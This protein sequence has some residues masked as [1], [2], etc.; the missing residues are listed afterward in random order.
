[1]TCL[2]SQPVLEGKPFLLFAGRT[3]LVLSSSWC[4]R[5]VQSSNNSRAAPCPVGPWGSP[6]RHILPIQLHW[7]H[8]LPPY[9]SASTLDYLLC[10]S[11]GC[12]SQPRS[13]GGLFG[14]KHTLLFPLPSQDELSLLSQNTYAIS[15][16]GTSLLKVPKGSEIKAF[17]AYSVL[18]NLTRYHRSPS[19]PTSQEPSQWLN[20][21]TSLSLY[22]KLNWDNR[23][24]LLASPS[25]IKDEN[26]KI[27]ISEVLIIL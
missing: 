7:L 13:W 23:S 4:H 20:K 16:A 12:L 6:W 1:M 26:Y 2:L 21:S 9:L 22:I 8:R 5:H 14:A 15:C 10:R 25:L 11:A 24:G 27:I 19:T 3:W 18:A 17:L